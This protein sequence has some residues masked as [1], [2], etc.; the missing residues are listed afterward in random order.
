MSSSLQY[1]MIDLVRSVERLHFCKSGDR[2]DTVMWTDVKKHYK[3]VR[4]LP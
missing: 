2:K 4:I 1:T 3:K